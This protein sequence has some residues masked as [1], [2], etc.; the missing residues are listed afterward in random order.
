MTKDLTT[1]SPMKLVIS[2]AF[3]MLLGMLLQQLY[4]VIDTIIVGQRLGMEALAGVGSTGSLSF[5]VIGFCTGLSSGFSIPIAQQFGAKKDTELRKFMANS[6]WL[7]IFYSVVITV[8]VCSFCNWFLEILNTP[9]DIFEYA[10]VYIFIVFLGIPFTIFYNTLAGILRAIGDSKA[11]V[12]FL[13]ISTVL[14]IILDLVLII[15]FKMGVEGPAIAT[16]ISQAFSAVLCFIHIHRGYDVLKIRE[17][18]GKPSVRHMGILSKLAVPMGL[19]TSV[20][21]IGLLILQ[22]A[23]NGLGTKVVAGVATGLKINNFLQAPLDA[24][25]QTMAPFAGQNLGAGKIDRIKQGVKSSLYIGMVLSVFMFI[26]AALWGRN[27]SVLFMSDMD[28]DV[29]NYSYTILLSMVGFYCLLIILNVFRFTLQGMGFTLIAI[30]SGA[31]EMLARGAMGLALIPRFGFVGVQ[32][33]H[34]MA[35]LFGDIL[36]IPALIFCMKK[37]SQKFEQN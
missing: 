24:V 2:F 17:G 30:I 36:L 26:L 4:S 12:V 35:W 32:F 7:C 25:A 15:V 16:V 23:I 28:A 34:P 10:K 33:A 11:P 14:N 13:T 20:T 37:A 1:G 6:L 29:L 19:Q 31:M 27:I 8:L 18:E 9:D 22:G 5:M 21:G 3:P